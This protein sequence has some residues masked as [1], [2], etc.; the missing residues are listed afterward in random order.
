MKTILKQ[1]TTWAGIAGL[2]AALGG[3]LTGELSIMQA[4]GIVIPSMV[5]IFAPDIS[6]TNAPQIDPTLPKP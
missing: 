5:G 2:V 4:I 3:F 1:K 6:A